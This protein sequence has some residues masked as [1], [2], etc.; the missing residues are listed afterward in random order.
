[1]PMVEAPKFAA[2]DIPFAL[3]TLI[4][5]LVV[6][7]MDSGVLTVEEG[8]RV[9]DAAAKRAQRAKNNPGDAVRLIEHLSEQMQWDKLFVA[10]ARRKRQKDR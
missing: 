9:F 8:Q 2:K 1:M 3:S 5:T 7:L 6:Q 4:Q 10:D